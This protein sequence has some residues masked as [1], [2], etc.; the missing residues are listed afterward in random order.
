MR[1]A[2]GVF[3]RVII[4]ALIVH[5]WLVAGLIV[6]IRVAG[7][8]MSPSLVPDQRM[9]VDRSTFSLRAPN[10]GEVI[11]L[12]S[13]DEPH[14]QCVKRIAG[15]P[16]EQVQIRG[17]KLL[18]DGTPQAWSYPLAAHPGA[19]EAVSRIYQLGR[20]EYF[21]LGDNTDVSEDSRTWSQVGIPFSAIEGK[22]MQVRK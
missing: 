16:G 20:D 18:I 6:P 15:L 10:R 8:S 5:T 9:L 21:V 11:V 3:I 12:A 13:P 4:T 14:L 1:A 17:H 19:T 2:V 22:V 7:E